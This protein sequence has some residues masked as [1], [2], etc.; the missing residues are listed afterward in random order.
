MGTL[1]MKSSGLEWERS[2]QIDQVEILVA[3]QDEI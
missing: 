1:T 3:C 2:K